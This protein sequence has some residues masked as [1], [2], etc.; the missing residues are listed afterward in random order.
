MPSPNPQGTK[1]PNVVPGTRQN[2][3]IHALIQRRNFALSPCIVSES[4]NCAITSEKHCMRAACWN[5][6]VYY[7]IWYTCIQRW[8]IKF[9]TEILST[10]Y[11]SAITSEKDWMIATCWSLGTPK[12]LQ[13]AII[14]AWVYDMPS[15]KVGMSHCRN[16]FSPQATA[17]PSFRRST[18]CL[19]P[20]EIWVQ[21]T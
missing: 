3:G 4:N 16:P 9:S 8:N 17:V 12:L 19:H 15:A 10:S 11:G 13:V 1:T 2:L 14:Q 21:R 7:I 5:L 6:W 20:A 18:V